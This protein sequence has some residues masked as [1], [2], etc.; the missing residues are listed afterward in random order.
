MRSVRETRRVSDLGEGSCSDPGAEPA[1][2]HQDRAERVRRERLPDLS[3]KTIALLLDP[4]EIGEQF[5]DDLPHVSAA[6]NVTVCA[7]STA[8]ISSA[9]FAATP[10][11]HLL[12]V[13]R[14][15]T[16][17]AACSVVGVDHFAATSRTPA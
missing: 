4:L 6:G 7:S 12:I 16:L 13:L 17:P 3:S 5:A 9:I 2:R 14:I 15:L 1:E 8:Q 10:G 11:E